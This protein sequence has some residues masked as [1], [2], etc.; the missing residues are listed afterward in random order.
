MFNKIGAVVLFVQDFEK[1][2][3]FYR[4]LLGLPV[5]LL[6]PNFAAFKMNEQNFAINHI[7]PS[8]DMVNLQVD[9]FAP[10]TGKTARAMLCAEVENVDAAYEDLV[11][12]GVQFTGPPVDQ[13]WG[14]RAAYFQDP[15]GNLWEILHPL[16]AE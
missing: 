15:E 1:C 10:M 3:T 5:V 7:E 16:A 14:I 11:Q 4:D 9:A 2:L 8:A 6:E 12:K 13:D